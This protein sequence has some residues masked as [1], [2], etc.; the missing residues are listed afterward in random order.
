MKYQV[1]YE[2]T[3]YVDAESE[4]DALDR[5][6][7]QHGEFPDGTWETVRDPYTSPLEGLADGT[8]IQTIGGVEAYQGP[9]RGYWIGLVPVEALAD[10]PLGAYLGVWTDPDDGKRYYDL[11]AYRNDRTE[12]LK[13]GQLYKQKAIWDVANKETILINS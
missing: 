10:V 6:I 7:E 1:T 12:A 3:Y 8:Y 5:A 13:L 11:T 9:N 4:S 2:A